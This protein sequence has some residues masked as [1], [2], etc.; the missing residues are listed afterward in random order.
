MKQ[1]ASSPAKTAAKLI[2]AG[3][4]NHQKLEVFLAK[5][6]MEVS[7]ALDSRPVTDPLIQDELMKEFI[8]LNK[9]SGI[10]PKKQ[11]SRP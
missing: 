8:K 5:K 1:K 2:Y 11:G 3:I 7:F 9:I 6:S 10:S 4:Y